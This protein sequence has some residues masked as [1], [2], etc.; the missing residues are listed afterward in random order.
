MKGGNVVRKAI[1]LGIIVL[2]LL[3]SA[4]CRFQRNQVVVA[5]EEDAKEVTLSPIMELVID[6]FI[7]ETVAVQ[8]RGGKSF[9]AQ[10]IYGTEEKDDQIFVFLWSY[11]QEYYLS[12]SGELLQGT[13]AS[14]PLVI[15]LGKGENEIYNVVTHYLPQDGSL[16]TNSIREL[17]PEK[18][19]SRIFSRSNVFDLEPIVA[20]KAK[21]YFF[22]K[23]SGRYA[24][25]IDN[26]IGDILIEVRISGVPDQIPPRVF[27]LG[28]RVKDQYEQYNLQADD[29]IIFT[30]I[31]QEGEYPVIVEMDLLSS[32]IQMFIY[33]FPEDTRVTFTNIVG[34]ELS[35]QSS[36]DLEKLAGILEEGIFESD[37]FPERDTGG[38]VEGKLTF[39]NFRGEQV[40]NIHFNFFIY[41]GKTYFLESEK[42]T[43]LKS[44][45]SPDPPKKN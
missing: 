18:Y 13:G 38:G 42:I 6:E 19:H 14:L 34:E 17:F 5:S 8:S 4:G 16:Y 39:N 1:L 2:L 7:E 35:L 9:S 43:E 36:V 11:Y 40:I 41:E 29:T 20:E 44:L 26:Q 24:G 27:L 23:D 25:F 15:V 37:T 28:D 33:D 45:F 31:F 32:A 30:Y 12:S 3:S 21:S 22:R 10:E